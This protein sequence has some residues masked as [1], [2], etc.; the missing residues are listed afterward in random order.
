MGGRQPLVM[1]IDEATKYKKSFFLKKQNEQVE[2]IIDWKK[3]LKVRYKIQ[4][5]TIRCDN[6]RQNKVLKRES[7]K[8]PIVIIF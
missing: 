8:N 4:V 7:D 1:F 3:A 2:P 5:M 6:A